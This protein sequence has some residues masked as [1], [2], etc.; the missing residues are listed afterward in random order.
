MATIFKTL[1]EN[2]RPV[3]EAILG[4]Y[5]ICIDEPPPEVEY[6]PQEYDEVEDDPELRVQDKRMREKPRKG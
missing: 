4:C 1:Y 5:N 3:L 2:N 6:R